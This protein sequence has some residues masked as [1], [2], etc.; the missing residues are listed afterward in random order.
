MPTLPDSTDPRTLDSR[1]RR[2]PTRVVP[3]G[4]VSIGGD[5]PIVI[6]SMTVCETMDTEA[7]V[8]EVRALVEAGCPL[9]RLTAPSLNEAENLREIKRRLRADKIDVPLI[10]DIHYT[11]D[12][13]LRAAE[14]VEKVRINPGNFA[15]RKRFAVFEISEADYAAE[16]ER[17]RGRFAPLVRACKLNGCAMRIG[18]NHG[19]LSDRIMNRY[20]DTPAGMVESALEF[21][22]MCEDEGYREIVL[23]MKSSVPSVMIAAYRLL[24]QRMDEL[25]MDY[26]LHLGVT[27][28]GDGLEARIK[29]AIGIGSLLSDGLG[30]TI[31]VSLTEDSVHEIPAAR[32]ILDAV[33]RDGARYLPPVAETRVA[34]RPVRWVLGSIPFGTGAP[35]RVEQRVAPDAE[36]RIPAPASTE[37]RPV[38]LVSVM[39]GRDEGSRGALTLGLQDFRRRTSGAVPVLVELGLDQLQD[40]VHSADAIGLSI[41]PT[42]AGW[43]ERAQAAIQILLAARRPVR[44]RLSDSDGAQSD[45]ALQIA[46]LCAESGLEA[47]GFVAPAGP[48]RIERARR[49]AA[50][51]REHGGLLFVEADFPGAD[52]A[53]QAGALLV[54]GIGH[55]LCLAPTGGGNGVDGVVGLHTWPTSERAWTEAP[56]SSSYAIL[57]GCRLRLTQAE[58]I[59]CPSCG[60]TQFDLQTTTARIQA[61]TRHLAGVKIAVMGCIVNGP[62]EMADADFGY[63]GSGSG[64]IDLY[65][66]KERVAQKIDQAEAVDRL[67]ALIH[68]HG[69]WIEPK[70]S[71]AKGRG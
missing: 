45:C 50:V 30:D 46:T 3:V 25:G 44:W 64:R 6:Q 68:E 14:I 58:F 39:C 16:L 55:V 47:F 27:E 23:S 70:A 11:P 22:Q 48:R 13:A 18:T 12:A 59:A 42:A 65:V 66:G 54:D 57:Q 17:V 53:L 63:V 21:V 67:I 52:A 5:H 34:A 1:L 40:L 43:L 69:R 7:A 10:A 31:R 4:S 38:E 2:R 26:P 8:R 61:R 32:A 35:V 49:L 20:G 62:G 37:D 36:G 56:V 29:S 33:E 51:A 28:A 9:V 19:S 71:D 41:D 24:V 60:R 15:D